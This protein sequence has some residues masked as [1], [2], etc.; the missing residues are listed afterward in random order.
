MKKYT[1]LKVGLLG[2]GVGTSIASLCHAVNFDLLNINLKCVITNNKNDYSIKSVSSQ[3]NIMYKNLEWDKENLTRDDYEDK[4]IEFLKENQVELVV[5]AGWNHIVNNKF[6]KSFKYVIN[7]HPSLPNSFVGQNCIRQALNAYNK[8]IIKY[9]GSMVHYVTDELDRGEVIESVNVPIYKNDTYQDLETRQKLMEKGLL[10]QS[11]QKIVKKYN[12]ELIKELNSDVYIGKVRRVENIGYNLL[13][14]S[15]SDRLS[16][17][18]KHVCNV[19]LKGLILNQLSKWWFSNTMDIIPNHYLYS[20]NNH[21]VVKKT[22]PIMLEIIVRAYMTGSSN[23]SIWSMYKRGERQMYGLQFRDGYVKNEKLDEIIITPTTKGE[24]D[25]PISEEEIVSQKFLTQEEYDFIKT[26]ALQ[27]FKRGQEIADNAGFILVDTKY[28]FG[29]LENGEIILIDELHTCDSSRYWLK[30]TYEN[31][32]KNGK[33]PNKLDKDCIRDWIK[34]QCDPYNDEIPEVPSDVIQSVSNVYKTYYEKLTGET[35]QTN[36]GEELTRE[37]FLEHYFKKYHDKLVV[38]LSGSPSDKPHALKIKK[39][40]ADLNI[41]S[42]EHYK[43]AHKNTEEVLNTIKTYNKRQLKTIYVTIAGLS[44][45]LSGVTACN[46][47]FPV[48][49]CPPHKDNMDMF[50]N[51][52]STLQCPSKVPVMTILKPGNVAICVDRIFRL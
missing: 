32:F 18:D 19:S 35:L 37:D 2:S 16:A 50:V 8:G 24:H 25:Y 17:F 48:I 23:T 47:H 29:R 45:A 36:V 34:R 46:T 51:I 38:I 44:N 4:L 22:N 6:I 33:E 5:L 49:A 41:A 30:E 14:M 12:E 27:L 3:F 52:N 43:S 7:L 40:L 9:T 20:D 11:I 15:T 26:K 1:P 21:M 39:C 10:I 31:N 42:V 13:L 28:E